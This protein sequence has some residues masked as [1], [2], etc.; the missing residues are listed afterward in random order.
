MRQAWRTIL[1]LWLVTT[2]LGCATEVVG[3]Q[4]EVAGEGAALIG[5]DGDLDD[6][7]PWV[8]PYIRP[9][10]IFTR[11][12]SGVISIKEAH[13]AM[14]AAAEDCGC[15]VAASKPKLETVLAAVGA[16]F[17]TQYAAAKLAIAGGG[18]EA[19]FYE[20]DGYCGNGI[21]PFPG[22]R[23][24]DLFELLVVERQL[25]GEAILGGADLD[26][27]GAALVNRALDGQLERFKA[28]EM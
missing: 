17:D 27:R 21:P 19:K 12:L 16:T 15:A 9:A 18:S 6:F 10:S 8:W 22:P 24:R 3:D 7:P 13:S 2:W 28:L 4:L 11:A 26:E 14:K 5:P 1:G 23:P 25:L 20:G